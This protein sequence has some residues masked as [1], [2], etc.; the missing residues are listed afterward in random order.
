MQL[1][2]FVFNKFSKGE[3]RGGEQDEG[4]KKGQ[5]DGESVTKKLE[6]SKNAETSK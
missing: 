1:L 6:Q 5:V 4:E 2:I 3:G